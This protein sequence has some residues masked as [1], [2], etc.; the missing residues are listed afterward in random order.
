MKAPLL[1]AFFIAGSCSLP[2]T[3][4]ALAQGSAEASPVKVYAAGEITLDRYTFVK[5]LWT[6]D[7]RSVFYVPTYS[8]SDEGVSALVAAARAAGANGLVNVSCRDV[9]KG[10]SETGEFLCYGI[11]IRAH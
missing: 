10:R 6:E 5:H 1:A 11:A 8:T 3:P 4:A 2:F 9:Q 7:L